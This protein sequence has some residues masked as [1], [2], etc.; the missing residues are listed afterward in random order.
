MKTDSQ[1][2]SKIGADAVHLWETET[3]NYRTLHGHTARILDIAYSSRGDVIAS[4]SD[5]HTIRL[6]D[7]TTGACRRI[8]NI[9][10]DGRVL[11]IDF[12]PKGDRLVSA[13]DTPHARLWDLETDTAFKTLFIDVET[14]VS[15][16]K[17]KADI[18]K[19]IYSPSGTHIAFIC[20][21]R[22][23]WRDVQLWD[24]RSE[25]LTSVGSI[26]SSSSI[27]FF[28]LEGNSFSAF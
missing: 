14:R 16:I 5:D 19:A 27:I 4:C 10:G 18:K 2:T 26:D 1:L 7:T 11:S 8:L 12:S 23:V 28:S 15:W 9:G 20:A 13:H 25:T 22:F 24:L 17:I 6:W 3:G 21:A